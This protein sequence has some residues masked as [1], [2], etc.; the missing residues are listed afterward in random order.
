MAELR[1]RMVTRSCRAYNRPSAEP[2]DDTPQPTTQE[3]TRGSTPGSAD[4]PARTNHLLPG[5]LDADSE[6]DHNITAEELIQR[7]ARRLEES[8][9]ARAPAQQILE[10]ELPPEHPTISRWRAPSILG[11]FGSQT[12]TRAASREHREQSLP[13]TFIPDT[14]ER[15]SRSRR[16]REPPERSDPPPPDPD[17]PTATMTAPGQARLPPP[18]LPKLPMFSEEG[19]DLKPDKLK[20]WLRTVKTHRAR[21]GLKDDSPRVADYYGAYIDGKANN[22]YQTL[23]RELEDLTLAQVTQRLQQLFEASTNTDDSYHKWQNIR[24]T[25]GG[26]PARIAKIAGELADLKGSRPAGSISDYAM[27]QQFLDAMDSRLRANVDPQLRPED[28]SDQMV[29]VAERYDATMYRTGGYKGSDRSQ[30]S[31]SKPHTPKKENTYRKPSTTSTPR[32]IGKGKARAKKTTYTKSNKPSKA[33]MDRRKAEGACFY[34]GESGHMANECPKKEVKTN[35]V[36]LSEESTDSSEGE[37][38]PDT[39]SSEELDGSGS[40]MTYKTTVGTSKDRPFLVLEFT[41]KI[42]GKPT[43]ALAYTG[44]IGGTLISNT[45][46]TTHDIPYT[47]RKNPVTLKMAVKGS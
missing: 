23:D 15:P 29:A 37:Y 43:R 28:T 44:T 39:D 1:S 24:Q 22:A 5:D 25:A 36:R 27:K 18:K 38:E 21:S 17:P 26:Q 4:T 2:T 35:H 11:V 46:V 12:P 41:I 42:N 13:G 19:E 9:V 8:A 14:P 47:A 30:A 3:P 45:F 20:R 32:N 34:C 10:T 40:V 31:S 6:E 7:Q 33:E 16:A